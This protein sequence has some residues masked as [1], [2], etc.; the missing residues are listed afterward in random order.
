MTLTT[1]VERIYTVFSAYRFKPDFVSRCSPIT[2]P[3]IDELAALSKS[4]RELS[5]KDLG[6]LPG[7]VLTTWGDIEDFKHF[8]PRIIETSILLPDGLFEE[9]FFFKIAYSGFNDWPNEEREVIVEA[10][11]VYLKNKLRSFPSNYSINYLQ[12]ISFI[13]GITTIVQVCTDDSSA[14]C[15]YFVANCILNP[16]EYLFDLPE[17]D[18]N[19]FKNWL[20]STEVKEKLS[21]AISKSEDEYLTFTIQTA[22]NYLTNTTK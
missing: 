11:K 14:Q 21:A 20:N 4:V 17:N 8:L 5:E 16:E 7:K 2:P 22:L 19:L 12:A 15:A 6:R 1:L 10:V 13:I 3:S 9:N 18:T